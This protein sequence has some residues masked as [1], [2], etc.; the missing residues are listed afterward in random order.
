MGLSSV[1]DNPELSRQLHA[2]ILRN[3]SAHPGTTDFL[4]IL[5][6]QRF[7]SG[8]KVTVGLGNQGESVVDTTVLDKNTPTLDAYR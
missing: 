3:P 2:H 5:N 7:D 4:E 8:W 1:K 6:V